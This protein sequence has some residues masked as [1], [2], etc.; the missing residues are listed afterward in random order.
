M[1]SSI[2]RFIQFCSVSV[3]HRRKLSTLFGQKE[4]ALG[5]PL[6]CCQL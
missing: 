3:F 6:F 4:R 2:P 5:A 1:I